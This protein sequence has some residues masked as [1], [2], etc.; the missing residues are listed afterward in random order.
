MFNSKFS[1]YNISIGILTGD[2]KFA[3]QADCII[4]TTETLLNELLNNDMPKYE[5]IKLL[6]DFY[7]EAYD[8]G[9]YD[10][11]CEDHY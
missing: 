7:Q 5:K 3:P 4:V 1:E 6:N 8:K 10:C 11:Y 9:H 2:N